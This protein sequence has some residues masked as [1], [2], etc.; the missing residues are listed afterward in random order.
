[1]KLLLHI[2]QRE[3]LRR[4]M[5]APQSTQKIDFN[6][7]DIPRDLRIAFARFYDF[8]TGEIRICGEPVKVVDPEH[9]DWRE[10]FRRLLGRARFLDSVGYSNGLPKGFAV[11]HID[12]N[13]RNNEMSN[14]RLV[15]LANVRPK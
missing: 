9:D 5:D 10:A 13:P 8:T 2:D 7:K 11:H 3:R 1:M 12:G 15:T 14:L 4:G 6:A